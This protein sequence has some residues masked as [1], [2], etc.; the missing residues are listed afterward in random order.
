MKP[1]EKLPEILLTHKDKFHPVVPVELLRDRV[2]RFDFTVDNEDIVKINLAD[3]DSFSKYIADKL[4]EHNAKAGAGGYNEDRLIYKRSM[5]FGKEGDTRSIHL[6]MDIWCGSETPVF[7][8]YGGVVHSFKNNQH[9]GDYGPTIILTHQLEGLTFHTLFGHLSASSLKDLFIG[10]P[11]RG[12]EQIGAVG[13][14][15]ENGNWPPHLHFQIILDMEG[16]T[17]DYPGVCKQI[18]REYYLSNCPDPNL[19]LGINY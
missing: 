19:I 18:D 10:K 1:S 16:L 12:G 14:Y 11:F 15:E 6:G 3:K 13:N 17:G 9:F 5:L 7:T 4:H 8:P 2:Y